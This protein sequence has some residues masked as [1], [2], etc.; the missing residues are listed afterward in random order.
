VNDCFA[1]CSLRPFVERD[2]SMFAGACILLTCLRGSGFSVSLSM[3]SAGGEPARANG[4][5]LSIETIE[6]LSWRGL[7]SLLASSDLLFWLEVLVVASGCDLVDFWG[8]RLLRSPFL[9][10][11]SMF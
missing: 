3:V 10:E 8:S 7:S 9:L 1:E 2:L 4:I 5:E 6:F 11:L